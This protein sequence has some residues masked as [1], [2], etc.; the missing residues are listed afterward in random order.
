MTSISSF[1]EDTM[2]FSMTS[3]DNF[4]EIFMRP[5]TMVLE[6][7]QHVYQ[8]IS[9]HPRVIAVGFSLLMTYSSYVDWAKEICREVYREYPLVK[10]VTDELV[11]YTK[12]TTS[13]YYRNRIEPKWSPWVSTS[14]SHNTDDI[15][16]LEHYY[17]F[18]DLVNTERAIA[19]TERAIAKK[20]E[21]LCDA[22]IPVFAD[23]DII[24]PIHEILITL[25]TSGQYLT[26]FVSD[27][28][29]DKQRHI[30]LPATPSK[31]SFLSVEYIHPSMDQP[32]P[33]EIDSG[34]MVT[35]NVLFSP[36][37]VHRC[38]EYQTAPF[39]FDHDYTL[40]IMDSNVNVIEV[41]SNQHIQLNEKDYTLVEMY[42]SEDSV[43][44]SDYGSD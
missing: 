7:V 21:E 14:L 38:L 31:V 35:N 17:M 39:I 34:Y 37:F 18:D 1:M 24:P 15:V 44:G 20:Y 12:Y 9:T 2:S 8:T 5:V 10:Q 26:Y 28:K 16:F 36:L 25:H 23:R 4:I 30:R 41:K 42:G 43:S 11:Y 13:L 19:I 3:E 27:R 40:R 6:K 33:L 29:Q 32:I 22:S